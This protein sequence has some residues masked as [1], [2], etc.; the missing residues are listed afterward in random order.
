M[1]TQCNF[2]GCSTELS[3]KQLCVYC[4]VCL[5]K[6]LKLFEKTK[7]EDTENNSKIEK[8]SIEMRRKWL[9]NIEDVKYRETMKKNFKYYNNPKY[10]GIF[11]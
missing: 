1:T 8:E 2:E 11:N 7:K 6:F 3:V 4:D 5:P 9:N 10:N